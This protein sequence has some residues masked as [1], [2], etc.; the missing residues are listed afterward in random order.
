M[1]VRMTAIAGV[2]PNFKVTRLFNLFSGTFEDGRCIEKIDSRIGEVQEMRLR[3][4]AESKAWVILSDVSIVY[5]LLCP[6]LIA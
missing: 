2:L 1:T 6:Q 3:V 5:N 4:L